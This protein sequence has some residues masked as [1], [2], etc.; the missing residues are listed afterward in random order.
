MPTGPQERID[1]QGRGVQQVLAV[2]EEQEEPPV[3]EVLGKGLHRP[4]GRR[5]VKPDGP[6]DL[7]SK[8]GGVAERLQLGHPHAVSEPPGN[9]PGGSQGQPGLPHTRRT[10]QRDQ[11]GGTQQTPDLGHLLAPADEPSERGREGPPG[12][13]GT[14]HP[15]N[16]SRLPPRHL[17]AVPQFRIRFRSSPDASPSGA[18]YVSTTGYGSESSGE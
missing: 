8:E 13:T 2:V 16:P 14:D 17:R 3:T 15:D 18:A 5:I 4:T 7:L 11:S 10:G 12:A 1:Q 6:S 9:L